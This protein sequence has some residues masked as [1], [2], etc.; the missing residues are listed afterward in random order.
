ML[1]AFRNKEESLLEKTIINKFFVGI[2]GIQT[3]MIL[4]FGDT[5]KRSG[6]NYVHTETLR[7]VKDK[8]GNS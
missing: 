8:K 3:G 6:R 1:N 7:K 2:S 4:S 5:D